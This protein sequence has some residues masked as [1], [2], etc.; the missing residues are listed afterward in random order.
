MLELLINF[1]LAFAFELC[2]DIFDII[3]CL[4]HPK[5]ANHRVLDCSVTLLDELLEFGAFCLRVVLQVIFQRYGTFA[6]SHE[7]GV[8]L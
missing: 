1:W 4:M 3:M 2:Y 7:A 5:D 6:S 8:A